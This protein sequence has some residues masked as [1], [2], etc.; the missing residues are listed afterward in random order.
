MLTICLN[1][2]FSVMQDVHRIGEKFKVFEPGFDPHSHANAHCLSAF[3]PI[4]RLAPLQKLMS[5]HPYWG[6]D[7]R[8]FNNAPW[9]YKAVFEVPSDAPKHAKLIVD[10]ADYYADVYLNGKKL[11]SHEGYF[12]SF[13]FDADDVVL[14]GKVNTLVIKIDSPW[15]EEEQ[16][17]QVP[18]R[19]WNHVRNMIKGTY[20][21]ADCF[22]HRDVNPIGLYGGAWLDFY[23]DGYIE[24]VSA[25][26]SLKNDEGSVK[27]KIN[28]SGDKNAL[29]A[30]LTD[31]LTGIK[32]AEISGQTDFT[33]HVE[34]PELWE[35][36]ERGQ[37]RLYKLWVENLSSGQRVCKNIG[38]RSLELKRDEARTE[39]YLNGK[40]L[41]IKG[42]TYFP[43]IYIASIPEEK[44]LRDLL[45]LKSAGI[46]AIRIHVHTENDRLYELCDEMGMLVVQDTDLNWV[47][48]RSDSFTA[49]ALGV[50]GEMIDRL[51]HHPCLCTW[52][53]FN[54]PDRAYN[55]YYMNVAPGPQLEAMAKERTAEIPTIRGSYVIEDIH[56]GDSHNYIGSL[57]DPPT[58][59]LQKR[60]FVEK[61][62]TE[63]GFDAPAP[64][65]D[66]M[67]EKDIMEALKP[68]D[69]M[70]AEL[71]EY[72][73]RLT[74]FYTE[75]YRIHKY[76]MCAGCF[77][78]LFSDPGPQSFLGAVSWWG[79]PKGGF[80]AMLE[81]NKMLLPILEHDEKPLALWIVNDWLKEIKSVR[82]KA[83]VI[84]AAGNGTYRNE[85]TLD[86]QPDC[87]VRV[88][89]FDADLIDKTLLLVI[90]DENGQELSRNAYER[91]LYIPKHP[92]GH[93]N[94][95]DND[96]GVH[97]YY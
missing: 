62:N 53:L 87:S 68:T 63:F 73:Y 95:M 82:L 54:E 40:R 47:Q 18:L 86:V 66:L 85:W 89:D 6:R 28:A 8:Q 56:S 91:P 46:N 83:Y 10:R 26:S 14:R 74:K 67:N 78:F 90:E 21:H 36:Y 75:D 23:E 57:W 80:R 22:I 84:D 58:E 25:T 11:G 79:T 9:W 70:I 45:L 31:A 50:F 32:A 60:G 52:I 55:D 2:R 81:S 35:T 12:S 42:T 96:M 88:T 39:Y 71:D 93:P 20:E 4:K 77:Q 5:S 19:C 48:T 27:V 69:Q 94:R 24:S 33:L 76:N 43:D 64:I 51:A 49:R 17:G 3:V 72:Q 65:K 34:R 92:A 16:D 41:F 7:L 37:P 30:Y 13:S 38:F 61:L 29:K 44:Y 15:D 59:Y 97:I 1:E